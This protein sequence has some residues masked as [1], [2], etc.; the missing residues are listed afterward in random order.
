MKLPEGSLDVIAIGETLV[1]FISQEETDTLREATTFRKYLGGSPANIVANVA[2]LGGR[3]AII[4]KTGIGS[5]GQFLKAE[6][7]RC[8]VN[9]NYMI[10][11][12]RV[13][14]SFVFIARTSGTPDFEASRNGDYKLEPRE[15]SAEAIASARVVHAS[16]F[17]LSREP[18][19]SAVQHAFRLAREQ[20]KIISFDPNYSPAIWPDHREALRVVRDTLAMADLTKPSLDD[21]H[22][23][24]GD[25]HSQPEEYVERFHEMGPQVVVFTMGSEGILLSQGGGITHIPAR[26]VKVV[27]VTGAGDSFWAAFLV[28]LLD[29]NSLHHCALF[30]R[31][32]VEI[33]LTTVGPLPANMDR[34]SVYA[35]LEGD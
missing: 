12:H 29:G 35:E 21:A 10:M 5:F 19:R 22:R 11:D 31:E 18:C 32:I 14:T 4:S 26:P 20:G 25:H 30:A 1:D 23:I 17:A 6:L 33:K 9:T 2:K 27:D 8:G 3:S 13:H 7:Q 28:A 16:T 34:R 15:V 24:W